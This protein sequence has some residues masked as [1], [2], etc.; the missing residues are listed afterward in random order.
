MSALLPAWLDS[1]DVLATLAGYGLTFLLHAT[2]LLLVVWGLERL[3]WL[4]EPAWAEWAWRLA[5]FGAFVSVAVEALP[6]RA[7]EEGKPPQAMV[8]TAAQASRT[9]PAITTAGVDVPQAAVSDVVAAAP[10]AVSRVAAPMSVQSSASPLALRVPDPLLMSLLVL[11]TLGSVVLLVRVLHQARGVVR[12]RGRWL[13]EGRQA[14]PALRES[15]YALAREMQV[16][17]PALRIL[18]GLAGPLVLADVV[19]L[20]QWAEGLDP[21]QQ[22][23]MLAHELAHLR[24]RDPLWRPLQRLALVPLFFHPLAWMAVRRLEVLAETLCDRAAAERSGGGRPLAECLAECLARSAATP[25]AQ[26]CDAGWTLAMAERDTGIVSRVK[27][28]LENPQM[29]L[30]TIP[31]RWRWAAAGIALFTLVALPGV[32]VIA[33]PGALPD[34]FGNRDLSVTIRRDGDTH[35]VR[36]DLP[37]DGERFQLLMDGDVDFTESEDDIA[38]MA[39]GA[40]FALLQERGGTTRELKVLPTANGLTREYR[41]NGAAHAFDADAKAWLAT[42]IPEIYRLTAIDADARIKRMIARGGVPRVLAEIGLIRSDYARATYIVKLSGAAALAD[43]DMTGAIAATVKIDSDYEKRR[44]MSGLLAQKR[45][46]P[47][48]QAALLVAAEGID[49][50]F[51]RSEWLSSAVEVLPVDAANAAPWQ[52]ALIGVDSNFER[53]RALQTMVEQ[54]QPRAAAVSLA[55]RSVKGMGSDFELRSLLETVAESP[56]TVADADYFAVVDAID[57]DFE[58]REALLALVKSGAPDAARSRRVLGSLGG[59]DSDF[60]QGEVLKALAKV[61]PN[62]PALIEAYR[63]ATRAMAGQHERSEAERALDRFYRS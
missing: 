31:A 47:A 9:L 25:H 30:S 5:L 22:R 21:H 43:A 62:D 4:K 56:A 54:G 23:A 57:S 51:E 40:K 39:S 49:S 63:A 29:T 24:R 61:M 60:E 2:L 14:D 33:R 11:W 59:M 37:E 15:L 36:S 42:A 46:A 19:L 48:N 53:R 58:R 10:S 13:R 26:H 35:T 7:S 55:L 8:A 20:P 32:L 38:R 27:D 50:D 28:L 6:Q 16:R 3:G 45:I 52:A 18:P 17:A 34:V 1:G 41:V 12:L 44:A